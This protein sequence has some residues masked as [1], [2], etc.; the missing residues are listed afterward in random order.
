M[1][2]LVGLTHCGADPTDDP[3]AWARDPLS[4]GAT[5]VADTTR[6]AYSR[7]VPG[8][9]DRRAA[10]FFVGNSFFNM[11][12]VTAPS[13]TEGRDGLGPTFNAPACSAC[14]FKDGRGRPPLMASEPFES[15]LLR[16][17]VPGT[18][19]HG[20]PLDEPTYGGQFNHRSVPGVPSEGTATVTYTEQPGHYPDGTAY[21]LRVP[22]YA[23]TDL[24]FGPMRTDVMFS[25]RVAPANF[26]LGLLEAVAES[27]LLAVADPEDRDGDGVSGRPNHVWSVRLQRTVM[28]R[29]G[30][31]ANQPSLEQQA[32]G[33]FQGDMG[34]T[35]SLF[36]DQNCPESQ[37]ACRAAPTGGS[38]EIDDSKVAAVT[39]YL[40][41]LAVPARRDVNDPTVLH[42]AALFAQARCT[43]CHLP[44][45]HTPSTNEIPQLAGQTF[46]PFTDLLLHDM[47]EGLAD[48]RPD[49]EAN[50]REWRTTPLWGIGLVQTVNRHTLLLH[51]GRAR[52]IEEAILW[53]G[54]EADRSRTNFMAM[55]APDR[56]ALIRFLESL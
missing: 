14:H 9:D 15:L 21:S 32:A 25:P 20:G 24:A 26:G 42:G 34:I 35:S 22:S 18:D 56:A 10:Q 30:W 12:W 36:P 50:G 5:T 6:D 37:A 23:F 2:S 33:A 29:I 45:L 44:T 46:H 38:P 16:L 52:S 49:Y 51:D 39:V 8:L 3:L 55:T 41:T 19:A 28:G 27:D 11:P 7:T 53:H 40:Q 31:K 48:N 13:S 1:A 17:S 54:G 4:G 47:G 43:Q